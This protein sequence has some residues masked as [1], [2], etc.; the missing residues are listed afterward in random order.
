MDLDIKIL[1]AL[2]EFRN[3]TGGVLTPLF[4]TMTL[5]AEPL[6]AYSVIFC[7][8]WCFN[9]ELGS[10]MLMS[11]GFSRA[12]NGAIKLTVCSYRPWI[13]SD[14][15]KPV[16]SAL[17]KAT[18]YSFPSGHATNGIAAYGCLG[19]YYRRHKGLMIGCFLT[20]L[21][22]MFSRIYLGV[23]T[24]QDVLCALLI[25]AAVIALT[26]L[27]YRWMRRGKYRDWFV[28]GAAAVLAA[29]IVLW[30]TNK[31]YPMDHDA[32]GKLIVDPSKMALNTFGDLGIMLG[33]LL[34]LALENHLVHFSTDVPRTAKLLRLIT[35]LLVFFFLNGCLGN[36]LR[37]FINSVPIIRF[38]NSMITYPILLFVHP[39]LFTLWER[40][41]NKKAK[42]QNTSNNT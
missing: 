30:I 8:F 22:I 25:T 11:L 33:I 21:L 15:I 31:S 32:A 35:G 9:K 18:G 40:A 23:H 14:L 39:L 17:P 28:F 41:M 42:A 26:S 29:L 27:V 7:I 12:V 20:V 19:W 13:R 34:G 1:L 24:P 10:G 5:I 4:E 3:A 37:L 16:E 2:Q 6:L 38:L 36:I